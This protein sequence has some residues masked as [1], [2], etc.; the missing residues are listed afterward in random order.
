[1]EERLDMKQKS[2]TELEEGVNQLD[3]VIEKKT[4]DDHHLDWSRA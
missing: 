1:L 2:S 4:N 3:D